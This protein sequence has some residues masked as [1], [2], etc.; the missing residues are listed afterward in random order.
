MEYLKTSWKKEK[1]RDISIPKE[2]LEK[3]GARG[4]FVT[5]KSDRV[6]RDLDDKTEDTTYSTTDLSISEQINKKTGEIYYKLWIENLAENYPLIKKSECVSKLPKAS[7][8]TAIAVGAG[9]SFK[10]KKHMEL[11]KKVKNKAIITTDR[12][13]VPLLKAG[14]MPDYV[15]SVDGLANISR[16]YDSPLLKKGISTIGIMAVTVAPN[17][18][19]M[20]PNKIYFYT[21]M[22][23]DINQPISATNT[24]SYL[25]KTPIIAS[26]G[27]VGITC[28]NVAYYL[29]YKNIICTGLDLGYATEKDIEESSHY[30]DIKEEDSTMTLEK[31]KELFVIAGYNPDFG[32]NYYT[33][34]AWKP[35]IDKV[36]ERAVN[37]ERDGINLINATE[38]GAL[39]GQG[40]IGMPLNEAL[41]K[42]E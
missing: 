18:A 40:I 42:Y 6:F 21:P 5:V 39:H 29:G 30:I 11:L 2:V 17:V 27:N 4:S 37:M 1:K 12:M 35:Q 32:V 19:N 20:F 31:Y 25:T 26:G 8:K 13:I 34:L 14:I 23:D 9:P 41:K 38:G 28:I 16:F 3:M 15:V 36:I 33:D 7:K 22:V 24:I 10:E